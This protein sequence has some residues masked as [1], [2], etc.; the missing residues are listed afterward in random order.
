MLLRYFTALLMPICLAVSV[1]AA[2]IF[3]TV[4]ETG[5][6]RTDGSYDEIVDNLQFKVR[7][8]YA[9]DISGGTFSA[10]T[11]QD[12]TLLG[13]YSVQQIDGLAPVG[14]NLAAVVSFDFTGAGADIPATG[15]TAT[16]RTG[17]AIS[18]VLSGLTGGLTPGTVNNASVALISSATTDFTAIADSDLDTVAEF[19]ATLAGITDIYTEAI[20]QLSS[21]T[22]N[23]AL[24][25][26]SATLGLTELE[27]QIGTP[28]SW[29]PVSL[30]TTPSTEGVQGE[31]DFVIGSG[32]FV[33][34][35][36]P[37]LG[38]FTFVGGQGALVGGAEGSINPVPE[39]GSIFAM[40]TC[41]GV[42]GLVE[43]RRR[44]R[45]A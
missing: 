38:A 21:G 7:G 4:I 1:Q 25:N 28:T 10:F 13:L 35:T 6:T 15:I 19:T 3:P 39:P 18:D 20:F 8:T 2:S 41:C 40:L 31:F 27:N 30:G 9:Q 33:N 44:R 29:L 24:N 32:S 22:G 12:D 16:G 23:G 11:R 43:R 26:F 37:S 14:G 42:A 36:G 5:S 34:P 45:T 17:Y